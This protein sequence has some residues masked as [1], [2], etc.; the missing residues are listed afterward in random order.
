M[1]G[2]ITEHAPMIES[3]FHHKFVL[4]RNADLCFH[5]GIKI[6]DTSMN[7]LM[8]PLNT[9]ASAANPGQIGIVG[10][11]VASVCAMDGLME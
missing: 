8:A 10:G 5:E 3:P 7:R 11:F 9:K 1:A 2:I 6:E 4:R